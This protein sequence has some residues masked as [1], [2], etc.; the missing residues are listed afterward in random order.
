MSNLP[1]VTLTVSPVELAAMN[2]KVPEII[3]VSVS[4]F[5][6]VTRPVWREEVE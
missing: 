1:S 4:A 2:S 3:P 5:V 6:I